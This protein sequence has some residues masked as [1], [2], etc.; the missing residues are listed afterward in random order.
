MPVV[1]QKWQHCEYG[2]T[3]Q[4]L[5]S[6]SYLITNPNCQIPKVKSAASPR[7][8]RIHFDLMILSPYFN[9]TSGAWRT[10]FQVAQGQYNPKTK[11][12]NQENF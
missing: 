6:I 11:Y 4:D 8:T 5:Q 9:T 2:T 12:T 7:C 3:F 10:G 1:K